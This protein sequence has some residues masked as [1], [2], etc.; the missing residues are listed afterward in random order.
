[1]TN[2]QLKLCPIFSTFCFRHSYESKSSLTLTTMFFSFSKQ[3]ICDILNLEF[4]FKS[5]Q[6][7]HKWIIQH[8]PK[9]YMNTQTVAHAKNRHYGNY[10]LELMSGFPVRQHIVDEIFGGLRQRLRVAR[11][12]TQTVDDLLDVAQL[13][14]NWQ[15]LV[16]CTNFSPSTGTEINSTH[17]RPIAAYRQTQR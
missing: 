7:N 8:I 12:Q 11:D 1:M 13:R 17:V 3:R 16:L 14:Q 6:Y 9:P 4:P 2:K 5:N 15:L 10:R